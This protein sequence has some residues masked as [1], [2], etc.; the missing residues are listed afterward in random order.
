VKSLVNDMLIERDDGKAPPIHELIVK[1]LTVSS[2][3]MDIVAPKKMND[4]LQ[5]F[6]NKFELDAMEDYMEDTIRSNIKS[7]IAEADV[8]TTDRIDEI[9][10][11]SRPAD[12]IAGGDD[13]RVGMHDS[14]AE[15]QSKSVI[16]PGFSSSSSPGRK[17]GKKRRGRG[18]AGTESGCSPTEGNEGDGESNKQQRRRRPQRKRAP[19]SYVEEAG[20]EEDNSALLGGIDDSNLGNDGDDSES[21]FELP[22]PEKNSVKATTGKK[23]KVTV[24]AKQERGHVKKQR[25]RPEVIEVLSE[26]SYEPEDDGQGDDQ[27]DENDDFGFEEEEDKKEKKQWKRRRDGTRGGVTA[28]AKKKGKPASTSSLKK[29]GNSNSNARKKKATTK[30]KSISKK[31]VPM[32]KYL[33]LSLGPSQS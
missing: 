29:R 25:S 6:V 9:L 32:S 8:A 31:Q 18:R 7:I 21:S 27:D 14:D 3:P 1:H 4:A 28:P 17:S 12:S 10:C 23:R 2:K 26:S 33:S 16:A 15:L 13:D 19:V 5:S 22:S 20:D 30:R 24:K 11:A